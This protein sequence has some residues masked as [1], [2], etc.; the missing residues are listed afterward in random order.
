MKDNVKLI[1]IVEHINT[2]DYSKTQVYPFR[3][4]SDPYVMYIIL[5]FPPVSTGVN[6]I[7]INHLG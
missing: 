5:I 2:L 3:L 4:R 6:P 7:F 1:T